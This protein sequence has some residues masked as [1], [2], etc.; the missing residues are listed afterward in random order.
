MAHL[1]R[2]PV[3]AA[4]FVVLLAA[5]GGGGAAPAPS[6]KPANGGTLTV[7][8]PS[9]PTG[10]TIVVSAGLSDFLAGDLIGEG[11]TRFRKDS[12]D[13]EP[14][15]ATSWSSS[16]D[17]TVWTFNLRQG[18]KWHDGRSFSAEDVKFT[19]E[20]IKNK[21]VRALQ[22]GNFASLQSVDIVSPS[23]VKLNLSSPQATLP[24]SLAYNVQMVPQ[25]LL[26]NQ[27]LNAPADFIKRPIGTG[28]FQFKE[29]AP[30]QYWTVERNPN[31]W[32]GSAHLN[33]VVLKV[34][35][36]VNALVAQLRTND[37]D[38][39]LTDSQQADSLKSAGNLAISSVDQP[40]YFYLA[41]M[42]N[43]K[44]FDDKRV[45][46][47]LNYAIDKQQIIK[48]VLHGYGKVSTGPIPP[49]INWAYPKDAQAF[50][51]DPAKAKQMLESAG[52]TMVNGQ[53]TKD[54]Q[55]LTIQLTTSTGVIDGPQ[56]AQILQGA[57]GQI[58]IKATI[59]MVPFS[60]LWTGLFAGQFQ[61]SVEY[62]AEQPNADFTN[63][64]SC[65]GTRNRFFYCNPKVDALLA[66]AR[67]T[68]DQ[69]PRAQI[70]RDLQKELVDDP[71]GVYLYYPQELRS[72]NK[73]VHGFPT[74]P[75]RM[76]MQH[77]QDVW[78]SG[79]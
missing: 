77:M 26:A 35:P 70:Y 75:I 44:P 16:S 15:L 21:K 33:Q 7:S 14:D 8:V 39:A 48:A 71:P 20:L 76:G 78:V 5:C 24:A 68:V 69:N 56:L 41:L 49:V 1:I 59:N 9:M 61:S 32:G 34:T 67:A 36:D 47:A 62:L 79:S 4:I 17:A 18:V 27:D 42:N 12:L 13:V 23:Q 19:F 11:L 37:I 31:W 50:P 64:L 30:G 54:G 45:R 72:I 73:R 57:L 52:F 63:D 74:V 25:H 58:G 65:A 38:L 6:S 51:Y 3:I 60:Q 28:P 29:A 66:K 40:N 46:L 55:Q 10:Y 22:A 2:T 53:L 43:K